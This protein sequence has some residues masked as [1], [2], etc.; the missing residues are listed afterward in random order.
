MVQQDMIPPAP[1]EIKGKN[2]KVEYISIM[3]Q[4][5]KLVGLGGIERFTGFAGQIVASAPTVADKIDGDKLIDVYADLTSIPPGIVR[6]DDE[7]NAIRTKRAEAQAQIDRSQQLQDGAKV[8]KDLS[9]TDVSGDNALTALA[10][11]AGGNQ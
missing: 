5:Q 10:Q 4:A 1:E 8:A 3:A 7:A 9:E 6:S 11:A 2:L